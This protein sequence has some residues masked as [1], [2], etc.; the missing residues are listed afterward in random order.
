MSLP[1][2]KSVFTTSLEPTDV[3]HII[4]EHTALVDTFNVISKL[5]AGGIVVR[6]LQAPNREEPFFGM[7][8]EDWK[9]RISIV[10]LRYK[11]NL[12]PYQP[13]LHITLEELE[14]GTRIHI[15]CAKHRD[16]FE[17]GFL[18]N[19]AGVLLL[20]GTIPIYSVRP[21]MVFVSVF[22][23]MALLVYPKLRAQ[24]SLAEATSS[25]IES[26]RA[27]PLLLNEEDLS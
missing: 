26:F 25:A 10:E 6:T 21:N 18:Y 8:A 5:S 24:I 9:A 4:Q 16:M 27:L 20:L 17:I 12:T 22:F 2:T 13:I 11:Q 14:E 3:H 15:R 23:G 19:I 1:K 7:I